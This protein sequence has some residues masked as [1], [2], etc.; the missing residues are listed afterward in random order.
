MEEIKGSEEGSGKENREEMEIK[1]RKI[2][3]EAIIWKGKE[4]RKRKLKGEGT[5]EKNVD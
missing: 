1:E 2:R 3:E 5:R 4:E